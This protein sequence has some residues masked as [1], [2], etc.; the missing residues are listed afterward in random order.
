MV[1]VGLVVPPTI[2]ALERVWAWFVF[3]CLKMKRVHLLIHLTTPPEFTVVFRFV[4]TITLDTLGILDSARKSCMTPLPA[5]LTLGYAW[6]HVSTSNYGNIFAN[7][8]A[9][10]D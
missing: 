1:G 2:R 8:E 7:I 5:I 9:A 4:G 10:I 6:V 3:L